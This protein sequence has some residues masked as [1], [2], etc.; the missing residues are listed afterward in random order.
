M[1]D[2]AS[3][4]QASSNEA[5]LPSE[6]YRSTILDCASALRLNRLNVK[7]YYRSSL[8]LNAL[9]K[10]PE[11][12]DACNRGLGLSPSNAYFTTLLSDINSRSVA[13]AALEKERALK[14]SRL[15][16]QKQT[17]AAALLARGI[18]IRD[19]PHPP[20]LEDA[21]IHLAPD[22]LSPSSTLIFPLLLLYPLHAQ[23][24]FVKAFSEADTLAQHL[25]YIFPLPWDVEKEYR[26]GNVE[27]YAETGKGAG[28]LI[29]VGRNVPL[30]EWV[31][32]GKVVVVDGVVKVNVLIKGRANGWIQELKR[33]MGQ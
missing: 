6:N 21:V 13:R 9:S 17:L 26:I 28:G 1:S 29:K 7:A 31:G 3:Q 20:S 2:L 10:F 4:I 14:E 24:D 12:L 18:T 33:K 22:P 19:S 5:L 8:A 23:S 27:L 30:L 16:K 32:C 15:V 25:A 11:A